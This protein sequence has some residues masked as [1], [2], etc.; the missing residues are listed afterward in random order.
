ML[1]TSITGLLLSWRRG[2]DRQ[3]HAH[4]CYS[5]DP[6]FQKLSGWMLNTYAI[7]L[8][9]GADLELGWGAPSISVNVAHRWNA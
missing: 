5:C 9:G 4:L 7:S 8:G 6:H 2:L 1:A 3:V